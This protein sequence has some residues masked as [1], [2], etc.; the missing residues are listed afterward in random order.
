MKRFRPKLRY[1]LQE[2]PSRRTNAV[3]LKNELGDLFVARHG[4]RVGVRARVGEAQL[5]EQGGIEGFPETPA[6]SLGSVEDEIRCV[7]FE[8]GDCSRGWAGDFKTLQA[9][10]QSLD[11]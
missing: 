1:L 4:Q 6:P 3:L 7:G 9:M 5:R 8:A 10:P 11:C 2:L